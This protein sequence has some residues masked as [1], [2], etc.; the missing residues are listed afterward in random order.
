MPI[1]V[2]VLQTPAATVPIQRVA[3]AAPITVVPTAVPAAIAPVQRVATSLPNSSVPATVL[4]R[5]GRHSRQRR[6]TDMA[7]AAMNAALATP[8][9]SMLSSRAFDL[10]SHFAA[11]AVTVDLEAPL[12]DLTWHDNIGFASA[13]DTC[14]DDSLSHGFAGTAGS[15]DID[16]GALRYRRLT[17]P[18]HPEHAIWWAASDREFIKCIEERKTFCP[19]HEHEKPPARIA[20]Y[21]NMQCKKKFTDVSDPT[22]FDARV[23]ATYGGNVTD[24]SGERSA[25][26][27]GMTDFKILLNKTVSMSDR[28]FVTAD[29]TDFYLIDN[30][31]ERPEYMRVKIAE[32]SPSSMERFQFAKYLQPGS[33]SILLRID[34]GIYGLPQSGML[35]QRRLKAH[36]ADHGYLESPHSP[37]HFTH[38]TDQIDFVLVVDDFGIST[39]GD[40][41]AERLFAVLRKRY[42]LKVDMTG[43]KFIGFKIDFTYSADIA[44]RMCAISMPGY[45]D[46]AMKRFQV[47]LTKPVHSAEDVLPITYGSPAAQLIESDNSAPLDAAGLLRLQQIN[48]TILYYA[49]AVDALLLPCCGRLGLRLADPTAAVLQRA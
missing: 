9:P 14:V 45:V 21:L 46:A 12:T 4:T 6:H 3:A 25:Q 40:G 10:L 37:C 27:S 30:P 32:I 33:D 17:K 2:E 31:L 41:P 35:A 39:Q 19:I 8:V 47:N 28:K 43:S 42:P 48:G 49:R 15:S 44:K 16:G 38:I 18:S 22:K 36:L 7:Y 34:N 29:A 20:S 23:R 11:S 24:Y 26:A 5:S 13:S 1:V